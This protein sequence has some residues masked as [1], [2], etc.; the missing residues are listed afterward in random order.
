M[1]DAQGG[2]V[3]AMRAVVRK[4]QGEPP[5]HARQTWLSTHTL[6]GAIIL[7]WI[8]CAF[9]RSPEL[10]AAIISSRG[11]GA[12]LPSAQT[13]PTAPTT[14]ACSRKLADPA[15]SCKGWTGHRCAA[16]GEW[17]SA[18]RMMSDERQQAYKC[19]CTGLVPELA[20]QRQSC[21]F[22]NAV[23]SNSVVSTSSATQQHAHTRAHRPHTS[24]MSWPRILMH[25]P[26]VLV[27]MARY[28]QRKPAPH[29]RTLTSMKSTITPCTHAHKHYYQHPIHARAPAFFLVAPC[30]RY[31]TWKPVP[32]VL[33]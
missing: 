31:D 4:G 32:R 23:I 20:H 16:R 1:K 7:S 13:P 26:R 22:Q 28:S 10:Y 2:H 11:S 3:M 14:M 29:A 21:S 19:G 12:M 24:G 15:R 25:A 6:L 17:M 9:L 27:Y 5:H 30:S 18:L 8:S 33:L